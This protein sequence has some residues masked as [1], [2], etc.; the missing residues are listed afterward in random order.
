MHMRI[1]AVGTL[2]YQA[3]PSL[4]F[5]TLFWKVRDGLGLI[6]YGHLCMLPDSCSFCNFL[7]G[8]DSVIPKLGDHIIQ[9]RI[10]NCSETSP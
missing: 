10:M 8:F 6:D 4:T 9:L 1:Y 7:H 5:L 3:R 2:V